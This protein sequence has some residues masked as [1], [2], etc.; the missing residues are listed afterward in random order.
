MSTT[1]E[2][3][4]WLLADADR[5]QVMIREEN[6]EI[7]LHTPRPGDTFGQYAIRTGRFHRSDLAWKGID[8]LV[9]QES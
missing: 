7:S 8:P 9:D 5:A 6:G 3:I 4:G 2:V 1:C